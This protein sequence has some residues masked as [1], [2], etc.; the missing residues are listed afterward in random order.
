MTIIAIQGNTMVADSKQFVNG[1]SSPC[2]N[3]KII[4]APDGSLV[5]AC[6]ASVDTYALRVWVLAGMDF[7][8]KLKMKYE[9]TNDESILWLWLKLDGTVWMGD[10]D[11]RLHPVAN[12]VAMG[13]GAEFV[14]GAMAAGA[15]AEAAVRLAI[16]R[17]AYVGG[18]VQIE[19]LY[20]PAPGSIV[21][22]SDQE[23]NEVASGTPVHMILA[24][25]QLGLPAPGGIVGPSDEGMADVGKGKPLA[26]VPKA[27]VPLQGDGWMGR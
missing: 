16:G 13:M 1:R 25:R 27:R 26:A 17:I 7:G 14:D 8:T 18:A 12:P 21:G 24:R 2:P 9:A 19:R 15:D 4:R 6:G 10:A 20:N 3:G 22:L 11:L 23:M 5:G